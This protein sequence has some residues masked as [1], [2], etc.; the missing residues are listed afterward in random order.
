VLDMTLT[1]NGR[2]YWFVAADGGVFSFG[3]ARF[4]GSTGSLRLAAPMR[5]MA[6]AANGNG[7]WL[8]AADGGI[9]AFNVPFKGSLPGM[10]AGLG[11]PYVPT[12]RMRGIRSSDGYYLVTADGGVYAFGAAKSFG[13]SSG[14]AVDAMLAR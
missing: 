5:S 14:P 6:A 1:S 2:G 3:N 10:R 8:V 7:Y 12:V 11:T 9:F 13:S 4:H